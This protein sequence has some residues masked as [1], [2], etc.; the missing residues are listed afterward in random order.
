[1]IFPNVPLI[2]DLVQMAHHGGAEDMELNLSDCRTHDA[3]SSRP[4]IYLE[5]HL[6]VEPPRFREP[7]APGKFEQ[8]P[9]FLDFR[10]ALS[11]KFPI[12]RMAVFSMSN[13]EECHR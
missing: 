4:S 6:A 7:G 10:P 9:R 3:K 2:L 5:M 12:S 11:P 13:Q 8:F 1:M